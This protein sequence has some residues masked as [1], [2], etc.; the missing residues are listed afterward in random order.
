MEADV[1]DR[2]KDLANWTSAEIAAQCR[3]AYNAYKRRRNEHYSDYFGR[4]P[5][6]RGDHPLPARDLTAAL[7]PG[8]ADLAD[9]IA[10]GDLHREHLSANSSQVLALA[11]LGAA[12]RSE[13]SLAWLFGVMRP[14]L[15][16][17]RPGELPQA[18]LEATLAP[19][20]LGE[21]P[22]QT[23]IDFLVSLNETLLCVEAKWTEAGLG[24]CSCGE[25]AD[26]HCSARV[27]GR[28]AYWQAAE[29]VFGLPAAGQDGH[30]PIDA[31]YQAVRNATAATAL[32]GGRDAAFGL[33]YD[34]ENPYFRR[35]GDWPGW[36]DVLRTTVAEHGDSS[37][38]L[39]AASWQEL[40]ASL[41]LD[42][43]TLAWAAEKHGLVR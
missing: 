41:P 23:A 39:A 9:L 12:M 36:P 32:A 28:T 14:L 10:P 25:R 16:P 7:P 26:G 30:C 38:R 31:G 33:I 1:V 37:V 40:L 3:S 42:R 20:T 22:R 21:Q 43:P 34:A 24:T 29:R 18:R 5:E 8:H 4:H 15:P 13:P 11:L 35:T 17:T 27:R 6:L 19:E 2:G